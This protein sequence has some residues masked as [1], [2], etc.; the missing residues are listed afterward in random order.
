L[1]WIWLSSCVEDL[2]VP[3]GR[4]TASTQVLLHQLQKDKST[5]D[6]RL[7][8]KYENMNFAENV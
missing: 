6:F 1:P 7:Q 3:I 4:T 2:H 5:S 8:L